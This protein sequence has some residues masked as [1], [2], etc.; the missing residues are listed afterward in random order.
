MKP[1]LDRTELSS[2]SSSL[3][4]CLTITYYLLTLT[5]LLT[6]CCPTVCLFV[7]M[8]VISGVRDRQFLVEPLCLQMDDLSHAAPLT[9]TQLVELFLSSILHSWAILMY[10]LYRHY[11]QYCKRF[12]VLD[13]CHLILDSPRT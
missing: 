7:C 5:P 3:T 2:P 8:F 4:S 12:A 10:L 1:F 9:R 13:V 6:L 11:Q